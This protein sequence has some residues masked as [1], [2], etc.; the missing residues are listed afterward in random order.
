MTSC[1]GS[2]SLRPQSSLYIHKHGHTS[3]HG[4]TTPEYHIYLRF[5]NDKQ[6]SLVAKAAWG[7]GDGTGVGLV[8]WWWWDG[9]LGSGDDSGDNRDGS[10]VIQFSHKGGVTPF[11]KNLKPSIP[12]L[13]LQSCVAALFLFTYLVTVDGTIILGNLVTG[14]EMTY[15]GVTYVKDVAHVSSVSER[16]K[17]ERNAPEYPV[18]FYDSSPPQCGLCVFVW[19]EIEDEK[20]L[21]W[22]VS[23]EL[24]R[25]SVE[26]TVVSLGETSNGIEHAKGGIRFEALSSGY[27]AETRSRGGPR[28]GQSKERSVIIIIVG[29]DSDRG[30]GLRATSPL[31]VPSPPL[32]LPSADRRS[33]IPE[34]NMLFQKRL[35]L[36]APASQSFKARGLRTPSLTVLLACGFRRDHYAPCSEWCIELQAFDDEETTSTGM[37]RAHLL[38]AAQKVRSTAL[39]ARI[40]YIRGSFFKH[41]RLNTSRKEV[42]AV[43][44]MGTEGFVGLT[45]WFEKMESIFHISNCTVACQIKFATCTLLGN[46][47]TWWNSD[48]KTV[49]HEAAYGM[50]CKTLKKMM[51]DNYNQRFQELALMCGRMF[52]EESDEVEKYVDGLP[53]MIQGSVMASKPKIMQDA[54]EFAT[55]LMDQKICFFADRQA[56]NKRK[57]DDNSRNN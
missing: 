32:L 51:T 42:S 8:K 6:I 46:A 27:V 21:R 17:V 18:E 57:L 40:K 15:L 5:L 19:I 16:P 29:G 1:S 37:I 54:I 13:C 30:G 2:F 56:E 50:T 20:R 7:R 39:E 35:C 33:D 53:D 26:K 38:R 31:P 52:L 4:I 48:V 10:V 24:E 49:S 34:T 12:M 41:Y 28:R 23:V 45:Q 9:I 3:I 22:T 44:G 11:S 55:E 47:L 14:W 36:T 25:R 43:A